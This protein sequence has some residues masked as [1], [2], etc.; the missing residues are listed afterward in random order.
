MNLRYLVEE[1][2]E[3]CKVCQQVNAC[4]TKRGTGKRPRRNRPGVFWELDFT[5]VKSGKYSYKYS[6]VFVDMFFRMGRAFSH[7]RDGSG[8]SQEDSRRDF[9]QSQLGYPR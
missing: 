8:H 5:E 2:V 1:I 4:L 9:S 6:T 3:S 7:E